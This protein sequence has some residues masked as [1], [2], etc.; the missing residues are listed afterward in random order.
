MAQQPNLTVVGE[1][2]TGASALKLAA[3]LAPDLIVMDI[4]LPDMNGIEVTRQMLGVLPL[5]KIV[6]FSGDA[7]RSLVDGALQAGACG[8]IWKQSAVEELIQA[9]GIVM[10]GKLYLSPEVSAGILED[11]RKGLVD[12]PAPSKPVL[13]EREKQIL[14]LIAEGRRNK[15]MAVQLELS[16]KSIETYRARLMKKLGCSSTAD[17]VRYAIREGIIAP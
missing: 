14:R 1:A 10:A 5:V 2:S 9:I 12:E 3:E 17:V 4:H 15:D 6:V 11:Y 8:Y 16:P 13:S 7:D